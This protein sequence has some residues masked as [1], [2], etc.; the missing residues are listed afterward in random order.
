MGSTS[1]PSPSLL[2]DLISVGIPIPASTAHPRCCH[3]GSAP[4]RAAADESAPGLL[5]AP[6][7]EPMQPDLVE[8]VEVEQRRRHLLYRARVAPAAGSAPRAGFASSP[9]IRCLHCRCALR[10]RASASRGLCRAVD[11]LGRELR[12]R[13]E[14]GGLGREEEDTTRRIREGGRASLRRRRWAQERAVRL[15]RRRERGSLKR[16]G[17]NGKDKVRV[18]NC[19]IYVHRNWAFLDGP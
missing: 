2:G 1:S 15:C 11:G 7:V 6:S 17:T 3:P 16:E 18:R 19:L 10:T 4:G 14:R 12:R 13:K 5:E 9:Q 8:A